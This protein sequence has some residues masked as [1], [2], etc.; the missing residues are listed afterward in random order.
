MKDL[1]KLQIAT[2]IAVFIILLFCIVVT[3]YFWRAAR[4]TSDILSGINQ[5]ALGNIEDVVSQLDVQEYVDKFKT[6]LDSKLK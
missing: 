3:V 1:H 6:W 5:F 4:V 2:S